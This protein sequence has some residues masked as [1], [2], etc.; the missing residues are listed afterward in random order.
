MSVSVTSPRLSS[1]LKVICFWLLVATSRS[2]Q[3]KYEVVTWFGSVACVGALGWV[4]DAGAP[5]RWVVCVTL[6]SRTPLLSYCIDSTTVSA[7]PGDSRLPL[8]GCHTALDQD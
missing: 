1:V 4:E 7:V 6:P 5:V 2:R 3:S 8:S